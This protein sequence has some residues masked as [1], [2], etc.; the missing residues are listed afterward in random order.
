MAAGH[1]AAMEELKAALGQQKARYG[2]YN[3]G[4]ELS[5]APRS[6][7]CWWASRGFEV[8][9]GGISARPLNCLSLCAESV[10]CQAAAGEVQAGFW[11]KVLHR[12]GC[13][14]LERAPQ[15]HSHSVGV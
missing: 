10:W 1:H 8:P 11:E 13:R 15:G 2:V 12:E 5:L 4:E 9:A 14:A 3:D 7:L 6:P